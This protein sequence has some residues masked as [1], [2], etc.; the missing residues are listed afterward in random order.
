MPKYD[1]FSAITMKVSFN[2]IFT[3]LVATLKFCKKSIF[4][5]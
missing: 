1:P 4:T 2:K 5:Y 3:I